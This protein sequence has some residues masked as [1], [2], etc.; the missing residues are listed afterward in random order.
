M[1]NEAISHKKTILVLWGLCILGSCSVLPYI[2]HL[3]ILPPTDSLFKIFLLTS[4]QSSLF[5]GII[6][7]LTSWIL[8][9]TDLQPFRFANPMNRIAYPGIIAGMLVGAIIA[10]LDRTIFNSSVYSGIHP[11]IWAGALGSIYG[12]VNEE[13]LLRLF[14]FTLI[15]FG[16]R[17]VANKKIVALWMVNGLVALLFGLGHLP[18]AYQI[19]SPTAFEISRILILNGIP[20]L[21]FGWLYWSRSLWTAMFAHFV[22]D[23]MIH[24][25]L[26]R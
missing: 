11:P 5:F 22:T 8:P 2:V 14:L 21:V 15:Y 12:G 26:I 6:C 13:V 1:K 23:L 18:L 25:L 17:K 10:F 3:N 16:V 4:A 20:G 24:V 9:K 19:A 7:G